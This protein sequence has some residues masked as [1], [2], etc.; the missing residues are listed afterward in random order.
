MIVAVVDVHAQD[1]QDDTAEYIF[2]LLITTGV[3]RAKELSLKHRRGAIRN[4]R[5]RMTWAEDA[6]GKHV[7]IES[8][9]RYVISLHEV[10]P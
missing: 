8:N 7:A 6:D 10:V 9:C 4:Y 3:D 2:L 1:P 5:H